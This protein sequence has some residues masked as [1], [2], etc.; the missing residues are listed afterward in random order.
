MAM[1]GLSKVVREQLVLETTREAIVAHQP[2]P[3]P[4]ALVVLGRLITSIGLREPEG[5]RRN[6]VFVVDRLGMAVV[7]LD[8]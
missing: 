2:G 6:A 4:N 3:D 1:F 7:E 5:M 8:F